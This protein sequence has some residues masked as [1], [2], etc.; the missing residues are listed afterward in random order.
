MPKKR[1]G[2]KQNAV[3]RAARRLDQIERTGA[4]FFIT[5]LDLAM[6]LTHVAG[7]AAKDSGKRNRNM[8]NARHAYD[9]ISRISHHA[10]LTEN[11]RQDVNDKLAELRSALEQL[12][13]VFA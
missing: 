11:E 7:D 4:T 13:E 1:I 9:D 3:T 6:T 5:D 12:G 8:A 10:S 2:K